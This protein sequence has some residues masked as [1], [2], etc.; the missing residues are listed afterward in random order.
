[1][2]YL[3]KAGPNSDMFNEDNLRKYYEEQYDKR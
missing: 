1:M 3:Y 2:D